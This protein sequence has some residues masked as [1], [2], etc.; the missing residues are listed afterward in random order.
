LNVI[1]G[2]FS[3]DIGISGKTIVSRG[4]NDIVVIGLRDGID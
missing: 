2:A 1:A 3:G 4:S